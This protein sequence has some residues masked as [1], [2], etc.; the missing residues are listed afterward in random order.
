MPIRTQP[1]ILAIVFLGSSLL[2]RNSVSA[3]ISS[4]TDN[5]PSA[6][7]TSPAASFQRQ[8][9]LGLT[10]I[11]VDST[12]FLM[13]SSASSLYMAGI[14]LD[15]PFRLH[16][17]VTLELS[18]H[19]IGSPVTLLGIPFG[20]FSLLLGPRVYLTAPISTSRGTSVVPY[21]VFVSETS[22]LG[23]D[24]HSEIITL[25]GTTLFLGGQVGAGA[26]FRIQPQ[27]TI[28][29][30]IRALARGPVDSLTPLMGFR[31]SVGFAYYFSLGRK[32][33]SP[34]PSV[35]VQ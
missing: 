10:S 27:W 31:A 25:Q 30:D 26:E 32:P 21:L 4:P 14:G 12:W 35:E 16:P 18:F 8:V 2:C 34:P 6:P 33:P 15:F 19:A 3:E 29:A 23:V 20:Q 28:T 22:V 17:R 5:L 9:G 1:F 24:F 13:D 7:M 11:P